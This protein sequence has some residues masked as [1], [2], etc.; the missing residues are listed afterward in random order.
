METISLTHEARSLE[1]A[2]AFCRRLAHSHYENFLVG[3]IFLPAELRQHFYNIY[4]FCRM[5]DDLGDETGDAKLALRQLE[6]WE[7]ELHACYKGTTKHVVLVALRDTIETFE[8]PIQPFLD[9]LHAFRLDQTKTRYRTY[10]ELLDYCRYSANPVGR[11]VLYLG[12]YSDQERQEMAD[13]TCTA[14]QLANHW[15]DIHRDLVQLNRIYVPLEDMERFGYTENDLMARVCDTRFVDLMRLEIER[16]RLLFTEG[17][18]LCSRVAPDLAFD[19]ELFGRCGLEI[20][21][22]IE[23]VGYDVFRRRPRLRKVD[24]LKLLAQCWWSNR[25]VG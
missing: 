19:I 14:L 18:K 16:T 3:S 24:R 21:R 5:S 13:K 12:R 22:R 20:L 8:I 6:A 15:Q 10:D 1:E 17:L 7:A 2:R 9:L 25:L 11:L 23:G 4:A